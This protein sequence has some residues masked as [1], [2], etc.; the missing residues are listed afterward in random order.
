M[1]YILLLLVFPG[2]E[3]ANSIGMQG[4][5]PPHDSHFL[6]FPLEQ[7]PAEKCAEHLHCLVWVGGVAA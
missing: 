3:E 2:D 7:K 5:V 6:P 1:L 4:Y